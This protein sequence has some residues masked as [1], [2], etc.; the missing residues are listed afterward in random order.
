MYKYWLP[1]KKTRGRDKF[2]DG[3]NTVVTFIS[4]G[5]YLGPQI[6]TAVQNQ[7]KCKVLS[8]SKCDLKV[9]GKANTFTNKH[10]L[11]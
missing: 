4:M 8:Q 9:K 2:R 11:K 3:R 6:R 5:F 10:C 1:L 7:R